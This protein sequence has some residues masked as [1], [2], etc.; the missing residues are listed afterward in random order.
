MVPSPFL[1][2]NST[3]KMLIRT[4]V[5]DVGGSS[6]SLFLLGISSEGPNHVLGKGVG[7]ARRPTGP[8]PAGPL[9]DCIFPTGPLLD[10]PFPAGPLLVDPFYV[11]TGPELQ[12]GQFD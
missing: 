2:V 7:L 4:V 3:V 5:V 10:G 11:D 12:F 9:L 6:L 8:F 1:D